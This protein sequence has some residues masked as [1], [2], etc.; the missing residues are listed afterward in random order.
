MAHL[1]QEMMKKIMNCEKTLF[2]IHDEE[3]ESLWAP[4]CLGTH[5]RIQINYGEDQAR[6]RHAKRG[7][8][9]FVATSGESRITN[10]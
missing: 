9:T 10:D 3:K 5:H 2:F 8:L 7:L 6:D 1:V 4:N